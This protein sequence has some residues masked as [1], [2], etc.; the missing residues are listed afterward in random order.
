MAAEHLGLGSRMLLAKPDLTLNV[1]RR[2]HNLIV[3]KPS[4]EILGSVRTILKDDPRLALL[5][6]FNHV[7]Y[8]D[9]WFIYRVY[10]K[11]LDPERA[12]AIYALGTEWNMNPANN[13][14]FAQAA[15]IGAQLLHC[16]IVPA[17]QT[18][19]F[20]TPVAMKEWGYTQ[21]K[22]RKNRR[23]VLGK[24]GEMRNDNHPHGITLVVAPEGTRSKDGTLEYGDRS[25]RGVVR[26][27]SPVVLLPMGIVYGNNKF[28]RGLNLGRSVNIAVGEPMEVLQQGPVPSHEEIMISIARLLPPELQGLWPAVVVY[29]YPMRKVKAPS[30]KDKG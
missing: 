9:P 10:E 17:I 30:S 8:P 21:E 18:Y 20:E 11:Y 26:R 23:F 7:S 6:A 16:E 12:R 1:L 5:L 3:E 15:E 28:N 27:L 25:V 13:P 19:M 24:L 4:Q 2:A 29:N 22:V 14:Q